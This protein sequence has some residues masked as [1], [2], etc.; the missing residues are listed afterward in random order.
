MI[1]TSDLAVNMSF[2]H[3]SCA[4]DMRVSCLEEC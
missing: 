2:V 4:P 3:R 1:E